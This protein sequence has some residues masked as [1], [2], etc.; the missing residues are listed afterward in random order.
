VKSGGIGGKEVVGFFPQEET[1]TNTSAKTLSTKVYR[2]AKALAVGILR[3]ASFHEV[4]IIISYRKHLI[5]GEV[6]SRV[7]EGLEYEAREERKGLLAEPP[8]VPPWEWR[9]RRD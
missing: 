2:T 9:G 7:G 8:P 4:E 6:K 1:L 3:V 5:A